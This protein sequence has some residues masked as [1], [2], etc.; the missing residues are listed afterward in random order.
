MKPQGS[1]AEELELRRNDMRM[2][3]DGLDRLNRKL[4]NADVPGRVDATGQYASPGALYL[5]TD[6]LGCPM[7]LQFN[8]RKGE[9]H[10]D[11]RIG[12]DVRA[13][14]RPIAD[15][16]YT[17]LLAWVHG[18]EWAIVALNRGGVL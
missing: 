2:L 17:E 13:D 10:G 4:G 5:H 6:D 3:M 9:G 14:R 7:V 18:C 16:P 8:P 12:A 11:Y 15:N 1:Y